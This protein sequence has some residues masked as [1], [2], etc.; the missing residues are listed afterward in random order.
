MELKDYLVDKSVWIVGGDGWAYDIGFGGLDHVLAQGRKINVLVLDTEVYS[1]TGGQKS[2]ATPLAAI[3]KFAA[4]GKA[5]PKKNLGVMMTTY[6]YIYVAQVNMGANKTQLIKAFLEAERYNGPSIIIAYCPC[7]TQGVNTEK[8]LDIGKK[9]T[10]CGYWPIF[11][12]NP[13]LTLKGEN[14]FQLDSTA[15]TPELFTDYISVQKRYSSLKVVNP[16]HAEELIKK[17]KDTV[18]ERFNYVKGLSE[19][20]KKPQNP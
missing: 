10:D 17:A 6:G 1:N 2:K 16:E 20:G 13:E 12:F 7:I 4:A 15:M 14:P 18:L 9:A 5:I 19:I 3:A 8:T 11:R